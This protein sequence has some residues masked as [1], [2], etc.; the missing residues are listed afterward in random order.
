MPYVMIRHAVTRYE[1]FEAVFNSDAERRRRLGSKGGTVYRSVDQPDEVF[2]V[3]QWGDSRGAK[4]FAEGW[5]THE[6]MKWAT[7]G[8]SKPAVWV[9]NEVLRTDA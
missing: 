3:L 9:V 4:E 8:A 6:A 2:I 5:E 1:D 7:A